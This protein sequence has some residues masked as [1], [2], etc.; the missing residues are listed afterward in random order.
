[1]VLEL[2]QLPQS[3]FS[4]APKRMRSADVRTCLVDI[5]D[6]YR[7]GNEILNEVAGA[8]VRFRPNADISEARQTAL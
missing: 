7:G 5:R 8:G 4:P 1:M 3:T 2:P 6:R